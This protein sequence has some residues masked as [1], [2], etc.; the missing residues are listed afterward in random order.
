M[1]I[2]YSFVCHTCK[3]YVHAGQDM[4]GIKSFGYGS[5]DV[6]GADFVMSWLIDH[7]YG[8][9]DQPL[10]GQLEMH[11]MQSDDVPDDYQRIEEPK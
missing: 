6:K 8:S 2:D 9:P 3:C 1:S 11:F 10:S 4:G 7:T 5:K